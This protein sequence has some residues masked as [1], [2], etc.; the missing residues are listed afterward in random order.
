MGMWALVAWVGTWACGWVPWCV[1]VH[2]VGCV[3]GYMGVWE[4]TRMC[5]VCVCDSGSECVHYFLF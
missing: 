1:G 2:M 4:D 3:G 5:A